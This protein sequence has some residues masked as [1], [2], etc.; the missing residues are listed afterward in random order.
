MVL[1]VSRCLKDV[2]CTIKHS[3]NMSGFRMQNRMQNLK[4]SMQ[5]L[6]DRVQEF[7]TW[8]FEPFMFEPVF[9]TAGVSPRFAKPR[10]IR[11]IE[12][13]TEPE[14]ATVCHFDTGSLPSK[15]TPSG[16]IVQWGNLDVLVPGTQINPQRRYVTLEEAQKGVDALLKEK[17]ASH[18][19]LTQQAAKLCSADPL[20]KQYT[21]HLI[22]GA[23]GEDFVFM[24]GETLDDLYLRKPDPTKMPK[25]PEDLSKMLGKDLNFVQKLFRWISKIARKLTGGGEKDSLNRP[26]MGHFY[27]PLRL[28]EKN[29]GGLDIL[30]GQIKFQ[31]AMTRIKLYWEFASRCYRN[32]DFPNMFC[33]LGHMLHL[34]QD[35][36]IPAHVHND[37]HG[38]GL[39]LG[40]LDSLERWCGKADYPDL[41][42]RKEEPNI[43]IWNSGPLA[44]PVADSSWTPANLSG[45]IEIFVHG[46]VSNT[47]RFRSVDV[48]GDD[49]SQKKTGRLSDQECFE[50]AKTLIPRAIVDSA[51]LLT[52]FLE[53]HRRHYPQ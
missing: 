35:L 1:G 21:L 45:K 50:Q 32:G 23:M 17:T 52:T 51:A 47:Q 33:A 40:K 28:E 24:P 39:I 6:G 27:D 3:E 37:P 9:A 13:R 42:R 41:T 15:K 43:R 29:D 20:V 44:P 53:F 16:Q 49:A 18:E 38:P 34:V 4:N 10:T 7:G 2:V 8:L 48:E 19:Y 46:V 30:D 5:R 36:H 25:T 22:T 11:V 26:Y 12:P 31:S 14:K